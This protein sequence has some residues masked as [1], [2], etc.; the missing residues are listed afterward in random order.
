[1][2]LLNDFFEIQS[3]D[4]QDNKYLVAIRLNA[5]HEIFKG[6]FPGNPVVPGVCMVQ[7]IKEIL[8]EIFRHPYTMTQASQLKFLTI[9][10]PVEDH[11]VNVEI[12]L[13]TSVEDKLLVSG[14]IQKE[15]KIFLKYKAV[16]SKEAS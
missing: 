14:S 5:A 1:M 4:Q 9:L 8:S 16:F 7:M 13:G 11:L 10:N 3:V 2:N 12:L 6:H 15:S